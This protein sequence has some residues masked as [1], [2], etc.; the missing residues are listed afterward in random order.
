MNMRSEGI[1]KTCGH[2]PW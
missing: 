2:S 1:C